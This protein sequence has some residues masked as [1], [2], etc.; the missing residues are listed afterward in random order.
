MLTTKFL[1]IYT[2]VIQDVQNHMDDYYLLNLKEDMQIN[3]TKNIALK[4]F[5]YKNED[6]VLT[7]I[8]DNELI[9][10]N[11]YIT[12]P[13]EAV[14][15]RFSEFKLVVL[16]L[17]QEAQKD[18]YGNVFKDK[19]FKLKQIIDGKRL[20]Y[21]EDDYKI[22][23]YIKSFLNHQ[24][25]YLNKSSK[26]QL[27]EQKFQHFFDEVAYEDIISMTDFNHY[28]PLFE[29]LIVIS[30]FSSDQQFETIL[31]YICDHQN[32]KDKQVDSSTKLRKYVTIGILH[33][34]RA[35]RKN[36]IV[37]NNHYDLIKKLVE[38][39]ILSDSDSNIEK[40][41]KLKLLK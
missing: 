4:S 19:K 26:G 9:I 32:D 36:S 5:N 35:A 20:F 16:Q 25:D 1:D 31:K 6:T 11:L 38:D 41:K 10:G 30:K 7:A 39:K 14:T 15:Y 8:N 28:G 40:E 3:K 34:I 17:L 13:K 23:Q 21:N 12:L 33:D 37:F 22:K 2:P 27:V 24:L 29:K 18:S